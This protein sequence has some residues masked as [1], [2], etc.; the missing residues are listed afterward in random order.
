MSS[1]ILKICSSLDTILPDGI[2]LTG[3]P[4]KYWKNGSTI[5]IRFLN[6]NSFVQ[7]KVI[8]YAR[9]W[10]KYVNIKFNFID[11]GS[12]DVRIAF[13]WNGFKGSDSYVGTDAK[14]P[15]IPQ[16]EPTIAFF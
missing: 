7:Q 13:K 5:N 1:D 8:Q 9:E 16:S 4:R 11:E 12:S 10:E 6:G 3:I 2:P 15:Q 14:L